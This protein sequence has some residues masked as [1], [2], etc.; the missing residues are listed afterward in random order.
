MNII[1]LTIAV[2]LLVVG[3]TLTLFFAWIL[4]VQAARFLLGNQSIFRT[5]RAYK[6]IEQVDRLLAAR[7]FRGALS[8]LRRSAWIE[9]PTNR[10]SIRAASEHN[11]N[12]LSRVLIVAE[13]LGGRAENIAQVEQ[14]L[15]QFTELQL[16]YLKANDSFN[17]LKSKREQA[18]KTL[19]TWGK[20]DF[21]TRL[22]EVKRELTKVSTELRN[23][24]D[25][26]LNSVQTPANTNVTYH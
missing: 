11:Q 25:K 14:L 16:L 9:V 26:L 12:I 15:V 20:T 5:K 17:K 13:E 22:T 8:E 18:G 4:Y 1:L 7:D 3:S 6:R 23:A 10:E 19:P 2:I 21:D 24:L